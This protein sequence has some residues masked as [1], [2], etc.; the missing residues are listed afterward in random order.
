MYIESFGTVS[1][2]ADVKPALKISE[3][4]YDTTNNGDDGEIVEIY[5]PSDAAVDLTEFDISDTDKNDSLTALNDSEI[6]SGGY[7]VILEEDYNTSFEDGVNY[8]E[9]EG[10][11]GNGLAN[12][13]ET[14]RIWSD[15]VQID[16]VTYDGDCDEGNSTHRASVSSKSLE[17]GF[18]TLGEGDLE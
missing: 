12:S 2:T 7:A 13:G 6:Q 5:N 4:L 15:S 8:F 11:I 3:V 1:G 10:A 9:A 14:L 18:P 17:C 16:S